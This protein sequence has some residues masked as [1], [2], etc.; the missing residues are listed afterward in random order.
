MS[1]SALILKNRNRLKAAAKALT[2]AE[3][4][5]LKSDVEALIEERQEKQNKIEAL[6]AMMKEQG[7]SANDLIEAG[8]V[9]SSEGAELKNTAKTR[10]PVEP[11]YKITDASG[12]THFW[13]G[14]G[15]TPKVFQ[16]YFDLGHTKESC[17][18]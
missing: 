16:D 9:A 5:K 15:R 7:L 2:Y 8:I 10:K 18:I 11:K 6:K 12:E 4:Q 3:L 1:D 17:A 14:R 13:S